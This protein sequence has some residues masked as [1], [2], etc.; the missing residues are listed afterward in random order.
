MTTPQPTCLREITAVTK[1]QQVCSAILRAICTGEIRA[2]DRLVE[3][4]LAR[5]LGVSQATVNQ[6]LADLHAQGIVRKDLNRATTVSRFGPVEIDALFRVRAPLESMATV[7]A[8]ENL[9]EQTAAE[10]RNWVEL[11]RAAAERP[12][13]PSFVLADYGFHQAVYRASRNQFLFQACQAVA[14][15]PFAY[16]LCGG[17]APLPT[18][19]RR[20]AA[21]HQEIL[22]A[23]MQG[24]GA[25][26]KVS[27]VKVE[28]WRKWSME[29]VAADR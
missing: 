25:V 27:P 12:D 18:D 7:A 10:I 21:D 19:Y 11:M 9:T 23:L 28:I 22:E 26:E 15:A 17:P 1:V 29:F 13:L 6:A 16:I 14:A 3:A 2:G 5:Q 8:A 20:L 4:V 24:P